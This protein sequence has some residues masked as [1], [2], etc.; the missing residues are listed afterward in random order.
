MR[1][2]QD[3]RSDLGALD[4]DQF[5]GEGPAGD[6]APGEFMSRDQQPDHPTT[7]PAETNDETDDETE[8]DA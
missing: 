6:D 7:S 5:V 3:P 4:P 1:P 2:N 8:D